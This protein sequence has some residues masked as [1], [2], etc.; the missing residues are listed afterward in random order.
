MQSVLKKLRPDHWAWLHAKLAILVWAILFYI[1]TPYTVSN[2]LQ[3]VITLL[4]SIFTVVGILIS[5]IGLSL[6]LSN[7]ISRSRHGT[8]LEISGLWLALTGPLVL[9]L[10]FFWIAF[11][12]NNGAFTV[13]ASLAYA[14]FALLLVRLVIVM[15]FRKKVTL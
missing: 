9:C 1:Y 7:S 4:I 12:E 5:V 6:A 8:N 11:D 3:Y 15:S 10:A 14:V 2:V 13:L